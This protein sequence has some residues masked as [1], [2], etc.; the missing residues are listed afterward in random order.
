[1]PYLTEVILFVYNINLFYFNK[2]FA[3]NQNHMLRKIALGFIVL[4]ECLLALY[5]AWLIADHGYKDE[6]SRNLGTIMISTIAG[7]TFVGIVLL[8]VHRMRRSN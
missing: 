3:T 7:L 8:L 6:P 5:I 1:M 2:L 4:G